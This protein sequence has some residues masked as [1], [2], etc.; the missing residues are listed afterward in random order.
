MNFGFWT[1]LVN[2]PLKTKPIDKGNWV[3]IKT[4]TIGINVCRYKKTGLTMV[5]YTN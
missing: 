3:L 1:Y 5:F 4:D 2:V